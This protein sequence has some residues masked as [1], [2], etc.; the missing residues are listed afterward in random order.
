MIFNLE[1]SIGCVCSGLKFMYG[2][3][4]YEWYKKTGGNEVSP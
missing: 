2:F 3:F 1:L 4:V